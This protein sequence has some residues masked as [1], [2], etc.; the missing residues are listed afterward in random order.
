M[1][2]SGH[3]MKIRT[4]KYA[5]FQHCKS[6]WKWKS[7]QNFT[8][9]IYK[10]ITWT[11]TVL[12]P[13][14]CKPYN[15]E[16]KPHALTLYNSQQD[17]NDEKEESNIKEQTCELVGIAWGRFQDICNASSR[18]QA[19]INVVDKTLC[20]YG[21]YNY[22]GSLLILMDFDQ[23]RKYNLNASLK[24]LLKSYWMHTLVL[25]SY[26]LSKIAAKLQ[27]NRKAIL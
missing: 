23:S 11:R 14:P 17:D 2:C 5:F 25:K 8:I 26:R 13:W 16:N 22:V 4:R 6:R 15:V 24:G 10:T 20:M 12:N 19:N 27:K 18:A 21:Y 1:T 3:T 7:S 9:I